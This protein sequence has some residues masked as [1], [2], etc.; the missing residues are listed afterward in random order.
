MRS[1]R[2]D[3]G[4]RWTRLLLAL[5]VLTATYFAFVG[6]WECTVDFASG[7]PLET[8]AAGPGD[9]IPAP[10]GGLIA[11][12]ISQSR[13]MLESGDP[14][15]A[16]DRLRDVAPDHLGASGHWVAGCA[17]MEL[18][19]HET[20]RFHL[21]QASLEEPE[22]AEIWIALARAHR[23]AGDPRLAYRAAHRALRL[24]PDAG[25]AWTELGLALLDLKRGDE[26]L[27]AFR[28]AVARDESDPEALN[29]IGLIHLQREQFSEA[30]AAL[31]R[32]ASAQA[33]PAH[34]HNNLGIV[35]ER[36]G[37]MEWADREYQRCLDLDP[38]HPT[39]ALSRQRIAPFLAIRPAAAPPVKR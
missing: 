34:V 35:Y 37:Y 39:A 21:E 19:D 30:R 31:E 1:T 8:P 3:R 13:L 27:Q 10:G 17:H 29:G 6:Q 11:E 25:R 2:P 7:E 32:A 26:A 38:A 12:T 9:A 24:A 15:G 28:E 23:R 5:G 22:R 33:C 18:G 4:R 20:A 36:L 16:L 14:L